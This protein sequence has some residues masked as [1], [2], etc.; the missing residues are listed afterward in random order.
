MACGNDMVLRYDPIGLTSAGEILDTY[1]SVLE[2]GPRLW[3]MGETDAYTSRVRKWDA[4]RR[5]V[6][7]IKSE[8]AR[9]SGDWAL[10]HTTS[11]TWT[12]MMRY[13]FDPRSGYEHLVVSPVG[14]DPKTARN[15]YVVYT[16]TGVQ[17]DSLYISAIGSFRIAA[18]VDEIS[19][20]KCSA[21]VRI[22]M[23]NE[24]SRRSFGRYAGHPYF[25]WRPMHSQYMWWNWTERIHFN[26]KGEVVD[27]KPSSDSGKYWR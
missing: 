2:S 26:K 17:T 18:T 24:M 23:Y 13:G 27:E 12:P 11:K 15:A 25:S 1:F 9:N 19:L 5:Q 16:L 21:T 6:D 14:T 20:K 8:I 7:V 4:V 22:W 3:I 10:R